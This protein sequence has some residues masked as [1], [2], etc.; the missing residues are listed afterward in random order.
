MS[1][2]L[3]SRRSPSLSPWPNRWI[4]VPSLKDLRHSSAST[5][6]LLLLAQC[7]PEPCGEK[8]VVELAVENGGGEFARNVPAKR[9]AALAG[10]AA[11]FRLPRPRHTRSLHTH[12]TILYCTAI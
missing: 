5:Y 10:D 3:F 11:A 1:H 4:P 12:T 9:A 6:M 2:L 7:V 8:L